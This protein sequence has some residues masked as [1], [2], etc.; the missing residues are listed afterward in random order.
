MLI[1]SLLTFYLLVLH[2]SIEEHVSSRASDVKAFAFAHMDTRSGSG[3]TGWG[4]QSFSTTA[5][6]ILNN[7]VILNDHLVILNSIE[8]P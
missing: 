4:S 2:N 6:V 7:H 5:A 3:M 1:F 8:D